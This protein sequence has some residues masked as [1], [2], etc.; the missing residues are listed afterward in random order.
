[1]A[2]KSYVGM[3]FTVCPFC[4]HENEE[5]CILLDGRL[6]P[7]LERRNFMG[8]SLCEEHRAV[9]E[10]YD[11]VCLFALDK[12]GDSIK[13]HDAGLIMPLETFRRAFKVEREFKPG[14]I[15]ELEASLFDKVKADATA[16]GAM[17]NIE[18]V[19]EVVNA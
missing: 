1:M 2:E 9:A 11:A 4:G 3:G 14:D 12:D 6:R 8:F 13:L 16:A 15:A 17:K 10:K 5:N 19:P 18:D 7:T